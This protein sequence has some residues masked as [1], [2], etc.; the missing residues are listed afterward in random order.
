VLEA[1]ER[2][3]ARFEDQ[4]ITVNAHLQA[5]LLNEHVRLDDRS[6][7]MLRGAREGG[8]LSIRGEHCVLRVART[9]ADLDG[10]ERVQG[11]HVEK[12][13]GLRAD[14]GIEDLIA[15]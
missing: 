2:Q 9:V 4:A 12:A 15:M 6:E 10:S 8:S 7:A 11:R 3:A 5:G 1:R 13:L 14:A